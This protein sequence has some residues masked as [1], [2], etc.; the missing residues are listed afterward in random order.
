MV[1]VRM[2]GCNIRCSFCDTPYAF[3]RGMT[4][5]VDRLCKHIEKY[6]CRRI[7]IT[8]G[9]PFLQKLSSLTECLKRKGYWLTA[10]TNGTI[11]QKLA[12]DWLTVSPK[13]QGTSFF[14]CG[15]D[16]RFLKVASEFKYVITGAEDLNFIDR[17][18]NQPVILQPV[19]NDVSIAK[20]ISVFL[21][22]NPGFNWYLRFQ[23][24]KIIGVK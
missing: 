1:F 2:S 22:K 24:H 17:R 4:I 14:P 18:I 5:E 7:C 9:E 6:R 21:K 23:N 20:L 19:N 10:E 15:Y 12:L 8:G 11:W 13:K 16:P 3:T